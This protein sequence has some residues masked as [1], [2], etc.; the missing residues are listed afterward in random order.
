MPRKEWPINAEDFRAEYG[1]LEGFPLPRVAY[2]ISPRADA[3][4]SSARLAVGIGGRRRRSNQT[5]PAGPS[6]HG[7]EPHR[8]TPA[9]RS[10]AVRGRDYRRSGRRQRTAGTARLA[11]VS[12]RACSATEN[13]SS[14]HAVGCIGSGIRS[15]ADVGRFGSFALC[16]LRLNDKQGRAR[17]LSGHKTGASARDLR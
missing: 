8:P 15:D 14:W 2:A 12:A 16:A 10:S 11:R 17:F 6:T 13:P 5:R 7:M 1:S 4:C 3:L 9:T